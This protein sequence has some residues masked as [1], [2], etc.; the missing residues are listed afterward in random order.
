[1]KNNTIIYA[2]RA[3]NNKRHCEH[4]LYCCLLPRCEALRTC[5]SGFPI[6]TVTTTRDF[7]DLKKHNK[8]SKHTGI[9]KTKPYFDATRST[10]VAFHHGCATWRCPTSDET[11]RCF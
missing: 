8:R 2:A 9:G 7:L 1:V 4:D 6:A 3:S 10:K 11:S 5:R